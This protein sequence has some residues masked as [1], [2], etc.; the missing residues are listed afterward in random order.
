MI[1]QNTFNYIVE[2]L[3]SFY[4]D[5]GARAV[6]AMLFNQVAEKFPERKL[7]QLKQL[8]FR[9]TRFSFS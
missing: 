2:L 3:N 1:I 7:K 6:F 5:R 9:N 4:Q 8:I